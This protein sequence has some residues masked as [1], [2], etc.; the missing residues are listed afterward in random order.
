MLSEQMGTDLRQLSDKITSLY[1]PFHFH[2][3][4]GEMHTANGWRKI[5]GRMS[6]LKVRKRTLL[7]P[8]DPIYRTAS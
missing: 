8:R 6:I 3:L 7:I 4:L 2:A 1:R 5:E